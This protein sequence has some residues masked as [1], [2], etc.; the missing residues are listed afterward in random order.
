MRDLKT[1]PNKLRA[2][3]MIPAVLYGHKVKNAALSLNQRE[4]EKLLKKAGESTIVDLMTDDG[5]THPVLIHEVQ[6]HYLNSQPIHVDFYEVSMT[7]KLKAK[8][9]LEFTGEAP[10]VKT[11]GGV[12]KILDTVSLA[13]GV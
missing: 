6:Y 4:F 7:E 5:K 11:L 1:K 2:E 12:L 13:F 9:A 8:V 3:G 10:A